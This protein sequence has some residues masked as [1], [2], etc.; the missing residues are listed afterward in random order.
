MKI[1]F[2]KHAMNSK[3][4]SKIPSNQCMSQIANLYVLL[5]QQSL[6]GPTHQT[7]NS[8][9]KLRATRGYNLT[10]EPQILEADKIAF[11]LILLVI[12]HTNV[13]YFSKQCKLR[14]TGIHYVTFT[15]VASM[16]LMPLCSMPKGVCIIWL[17]GKWQ[18]SEVHVTISSGFHQRK[19]PE[20]SCWC[21]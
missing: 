15:C 7:C 16:V 12:A 13:L 21:K 1:A 6:N 17:Q 14:N 19:Q 8:V 20:G 4:E 5:I 18:S 2:G 10:S 11:I 9:S 3:H